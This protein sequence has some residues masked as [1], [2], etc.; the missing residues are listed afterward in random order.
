MSKLELLEQ[1]KHGLTV[2]CQALPDEPLYSPFI[3]AKMAKA[4]K[5]GGAVAIRANGQ[6]DILAIRGEVDLPIIGIVKK[7]YS[8]SPIYITP[9]LAEVEELV[10]VGCSIIAVDATNRIRPG[11]TTLQEFYRNVREVFPNLML[12]ADISTFEEGVYAM[13]LGFDLV[14]TT[15]AGY[16]PYTEEISLPALSLVEQLARLERAPVMAEGGYWEPKQLSEALRL[17]AHGCIVG[18]AITRPFEITK[19]FV[20]TLHTEES[21]R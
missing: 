15:L 8:D 21:T 19:R 17:G 5:L 13:D 10:K 12:M 3:M 1:L 20:T 7:D 16:T 11:G 9:T 2:S 18:S 14:A 4:A 6:A